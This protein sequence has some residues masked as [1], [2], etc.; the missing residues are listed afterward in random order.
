MVNIRKNTAA[1]WAAEN[2]T[3]RSGELGVEK[4]TKKYK[5][6]DGV[7]TW[8]NLP[9]Q[10]DKVMADASYA[11]IA[12]SANYATLDLGSK[13]LEE[14]IPTRLSVSDLSSAYAGKIVET[15]KLDKAEAVATYATRGDI[16]MSTAIALQEG[17]NS[18]GISAMGD[19]TTTPDTAW[20]RLLANEVAV[21]FPAF[22]HRYWKWNDTTQ[23][24]DAP[25]AITPEGTKRG[26]KMAAGTSSQRVGAQ[27]TGTNITGDIEIDV[28]M[29]HP[30]WVSG[31]TQCIAHKWTD[32]L[33]RSWILYLMPTGTLRFVWYTDGV[34]AGGDKTSTVAV[35]FANG[36]PGWVRV[37]LDVDNG[38]SGHDVK[39]YT[40]TDRVTWTQLGTTITT[41]I[42]TT[43]FAG[44]SRYGWG[45]RGSNALSTDSII[46]EIHIKDGLNGF[47]VVPILPELWSR[48]IGIY[49]PM[50]VGK[51]VVEWVLGAHPGAG[52]GYDY[53]TTGYLLASNRAKKMSLHVGSFVTFFNSSHNE[54]NLTGKAWHEKYMQWVNES[55]TDKPLTARVAL[56]QNPRTGTAS[57]NGADHG[58]RARRAA[59]LNLSRRSL[60]VDAIDTYQAFLDDGRDLATILIGDGVHPTGV[61]YEVEKDA[62]KAELDAAIARV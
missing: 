41:L 54:Y 9:Y 36:V 14:N 42:A 58:H 62:I 39:F 16:F 17:V 47:G 19:S 37:T 51:P 35:P 59:M 61:G 12:G 52:I 43:I 25:I 11:P 10:F 31:E 55:T 4:D 30:L 34:T 44:T 3:L 45:N 8:V 57:D 38:G 24:F 50:V 20:F 53:V 7:T 1:Q 6:G 22:H 33:Q 49:A 48:T 21:D 56:T 28:N 18:F 27:I 60:G 40:S 13:I 46:H 15:S 23:R 32:D 29:T 26:L 2:P 5:I